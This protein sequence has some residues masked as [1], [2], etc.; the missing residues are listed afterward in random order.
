MEIVPTMGILAEVWIENVTTSPSVQVYIS[1]HGKVEVISTHEQILDGQIY[2][3]CQCPADLCY[4]AQLMEQGKLLGG[5]VFHV[6]GTL[7]PFGKV[8]LAAIADSIAE[9]DALYEKACKTMMEV[10][11]SEGQSAHSLWI[12]RYED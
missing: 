6:M 4:A 5:V 1:P 3:G 12:D 11:A 10:G 7:S 9:A 2:L 8:G